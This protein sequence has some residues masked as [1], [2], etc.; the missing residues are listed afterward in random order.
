MLERLLKISVFIFFSLMILLIGLQ[1]FL[2]YVLNN[3][4]AWS[5]EAAR[6][7]VVY[8]CFFG[9]CLA[10]LR[11]EGLRVTFFIK[12]FPPKAAIHVDI[13]M[14]S[15]IIVFLLFV[16]VF[17]TLAMFKLRNQLTTALQWPKS[18]LYF[19]LLPSVS[20]MALITFKQIKGCLNRLKH[21]NSNDNS[22][23]S[24]DQ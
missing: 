22:K 5:E 14:K 3:P 7:S 21:L 1:V 24:A 11:E 10:M 16:L 9:A 13:L 15:L 23:R 6:F 8:L 20:F 4:N 19:S 2:R 17:G 12:K 18:I